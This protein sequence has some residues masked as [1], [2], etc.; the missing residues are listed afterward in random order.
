MSLI[1]HG[2]I[3]AVV[4]GL[5]AG[6]RFIGQDFHPA[7]GIRIQPAVELLAP[8][9]PKRRRAD[10]ENAFRVRPIDELRCLDCLAEPG[11]IRENRAP[12]AAGKGDQFFH[13]L[14]LIGAELIR[15]I[16][17]HL[18]SLIVFAFIL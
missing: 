18:A 15:L 3:A 5:A 4:A 2:K 17:L 11:F 13:T 16:G 12:A 8:V 6:N 14:D 7:H 10:D 9:D 1:E